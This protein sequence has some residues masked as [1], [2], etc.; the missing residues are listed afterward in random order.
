MDGDIFL[1]ETEKRLAL[2]QVV[3]LGLLELA[4]ADLASTRSEGAWWSRH[5]KR[6]GAGEDRRGEEKDRSWA[7]SP[8]ASSR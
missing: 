3:K 5:V 7:P 6:G 2:E 4:A 8:V 1:Q